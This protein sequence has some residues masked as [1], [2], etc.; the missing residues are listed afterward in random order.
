MGQLRFSASIQGSTF[1]HSPGC[2]AH[3]FVLRR[4]FP[5]WS[6]AMVIM[7]HL[8]AV[9]SSLE[10]AAAPEASVIINVL[11]DWA[12]DRFGIAGSKTEN[13]WSEPDSDE[14]ENHSPG[15]G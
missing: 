5:V 14:S 13:H 3:H 11:S 2:D 12:L 8:V 1:T 15:S 4:Q 6:S 10:C 7:I 9:T